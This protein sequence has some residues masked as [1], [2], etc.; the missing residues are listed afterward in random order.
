MS[1]VPATLRLQGQWRMTLPALGALLLAILWLYRGDA[2]PQNNPANPKYRAF[3]GLWRR[4][5][6]VVANRLGPFIVRSLG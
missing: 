5:P 1:A 2:I 6:L 4:L 3:I